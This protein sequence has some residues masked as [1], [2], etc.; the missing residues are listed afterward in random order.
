M[1]DFKNRDGLLCPTFFLLLVFVPRRPVLFLLIPL[2]FYA[3]SAYIIAPTAPVII[4]SPFYIKGTCPH[5]EHVF[6][7]DS[8]LFQS[9]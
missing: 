9:I 2:L 8:C 4:S 5:R 1:T 3:W 6:P 7:S